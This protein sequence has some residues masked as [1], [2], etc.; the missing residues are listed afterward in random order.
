M[1]RKKKKPTVN[2]KDIINKN[3]DKAS[4]AKWKA[5][6]DKP[7]LEMDEKE[8]P[9]ASEEEK[10]D[11][12][13]KW[14]MLDMADQFYEREESAK[15]VLATDAAKD[16][17]R[18]VFAKA[19]S[20]RECTEL[21]ANKNLQAAI[22]GP[23]LADTKLS[24]AQA[25]EAFAKDL[26]D[27]D[28]AKQELEDKKKNF[29]FDD[30]RYAKAT[31][32]EKLQKMKDYMKM[33]AAP[34][35][36]GK[37]NKFAKHLDTD[38]GRSLMKQTMRKAKSWTECKKYLGS[39]NLM[40][41]LIE[42]MSN[43]SK[44]HGTALDNYLEKDLKPDYIYPW[45]ILRNGG[46]ALQS[47]SRAD[48]YGPDT[49]ADGTYREDFY[50]KLA[51][52]GW[53]IDGNEKLVATIY[54]IAAEY[55][56]QPGADKDLLKKIMDSPAGTVAQQD[57]IRKDV[58]DVLKKL[59]G[60]HI[61][62]VAIL[63]TREKYY[64][65]HE[66]MRERGWDQPGD[67]AIIDALYSHGS[68]KKIRYA[69]ES[70]EK[71]ALDIAKSS[72]KG[73]R[74]RIDAINLIDKEELKRLDPKL[75]D[76]IDKIEQDLLKRREIAEA[77][78]RLKA[79]PNLRSLFKQ[80]IEA[81]L[82]EI[83]LEAVPSRDTSTE[84][85]AGL[86]FKDVKPDAET[87]A[88]LKEDISKLPIDE[89]LVKKGPNELESALAE[90]YENMIKQRFGD[91]MDT[92]YFKYLSWDK[93]IGANTPDEV[94]QKILDFAVSG[95]T[96]Q[97]RYDAADKYMLE[98]PGEH[99]R[100]EKIMSSVQDL[101]V[102]IKTLKSKKNKAFYEKAK[103]NG[104]VADDIP[105]YNIEYPDPRVRTYFED[106]NE[107][108]MQEFGNV[109]KKAAGINHPKDLINEQNIA[110]S[111][112]DARSEKKIGNAQI[113]RI[114]KLFTDLSDNGF[115]WDEFR[116]TGTY[117]SFLYNHDVKEHSSYD[118]FEIAKASCGMR[119]ELKHL[120]EFCSSENADMT[121]KMLEEITEEYSA[122]KEAM[123]NMRTDSVG[124]WLATN[125]FDLLK[126]S[127]MATNGFDVQKVNGKEVPVVNFSEE[128]S[129]DKI[130]R[131]LMADGS[132]Q[133]MVNAAKE[134]QKLYS[135]NKYLFDEF[136]DNVYTHRNYDGMAL[137]NVMSKYR[138]MDEDPE[139]SQKINRF[140]HLIYKLK[141]ADKNVCKLIDMKN[142]KNEILVEP[143]PED[144]K[145]DK[146]M[147]AKEVELL[148]NCIQMLKEP[149]E[150]VHRN[151]P[152]YVKIMESIQTLKNNLKKD[153]PDNQTAKD[154]YIK[155]VNKVL[156]NINR[157]RIH[158]AAD[159]IKNDATH[160]KIV[161]AE[162]VD[163]FLSTRYRTLEKADYLDKLDGVADLFKVDIKDKKLTGDDYLL[164]KGVG[165][166]E[167]M[168][169]N[170]E[171]IR[172]EMEKQEKVKRSN[173][174]GGIR[175]SKAGA[176]AQQGRNTLNK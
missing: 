147:V 47:D 140:R 154:E 27:L 80:V 174:I 158:K 112:W 130:D 108:E 96:T 73:Y 75:F 176:E 77:E 86:K 171:K 46:L 64:D 4:Y 105:V 102:I 32:A 78:A 67:E 16:I 107:A 12:A 93:M 39:L 152:E 2:A 114:Q 48:L 153:Y 161:A 24:Y 89:E 71:Q 90:D 150:R 65:F 85:I 84:I 116:W 41:A 138:D 123:F 60:K 62:Q 18:Q 137:R 109:I 122:K 160:D 69:K 38:S 13:G 99:T 117:K 19:S 100:A 25:K 136:F 21:L 104:G 37:E 125:G 144:T 72:P 15:N 88:Q 167:N 44:L 169:K 35:I 36:K 29:D 3:K 148:D 124:L 61:E 70:I 28:K 34:F 155:G 59:P 10:L 17:L 151:S 83:D 133:E 111:F 159:G 139:K 170:M 127:V 164:A 115:S 76:K 53:D 163:K 87:V 103:A 110:D 82:D 40:N 52:N 98:N 55:V 95:M 142:D 149:A 134:A 45:Q 92:R 22:F 81:G 101:S 23:Q 14:L 146:T 49:A 120:K 121:I 54:K 129:E 162:R 128:I 132:Y 173:S 94:R 91:K 20:W 131:D 9:K 51:E 157:Y 66:K 30:D 43:N 5:E 106:I 26:A 135:D 79:N 145:F 143:L 63:K 68:E 31:D 50:D 126:N 141:S 119:S 7:Y 166:I 172:Q 11:V 1:P 56:K 74:G 113:K 42:E 165:K 8:Y 33:L 58:L 57:K 168:R 97:M 118:P 6:G 156:N 175:N